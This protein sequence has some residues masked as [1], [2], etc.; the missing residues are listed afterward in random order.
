MPIRIDPLTLRL[1]N[2]IYQRIL[3]EL[4]FT[5]QLPKRILFTKKNHNSFNDFKFFIDIEFEKYLST[6]SFAE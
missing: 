6:V 4:D 5:R 2:G 1:Y 3:V